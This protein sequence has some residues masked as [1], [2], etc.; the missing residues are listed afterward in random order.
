M[1]EIC[2]RI[3]I[4]VWLIILNSAVISYFFQDLDLI[5][6]QKIIKCEITT[7]GA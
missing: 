3:H 4:I 1:E 2:G 5:K 6:I 7:M